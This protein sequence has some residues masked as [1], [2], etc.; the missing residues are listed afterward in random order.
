[1]VEYDYK[2]FLSLTNLEKKIQR[3][4]KSCI[5]DLALVSFFIHRRITKLDKRTGSKVIFM[6]NHPEL[7][8]LDG[9]DIYAD[10]S[11]DGKINN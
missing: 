5:T 4:Y 8:R 7:G 2:N 10:E 1:M 3:V 6:S 11:Q 9:L